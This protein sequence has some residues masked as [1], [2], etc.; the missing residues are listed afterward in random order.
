M[1]AEERWQ[2]VVL[3]VYPPDW[4]YPPDSCAVAQAAGMQLKEAAECAALRAL[5]QV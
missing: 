4:W 3:G 2:L 5:E 1:Y